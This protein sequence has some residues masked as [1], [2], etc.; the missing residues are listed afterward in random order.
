LL[1]FVLQTELKAQT[2]PFRGVLLEHFGGHTCPN[3]TRADSKSEQIK[4]MYHDSVAIINIQSGTFALPSTY[5]S[6]P[7][8]DDLSCSTGESLDTFSLVYSTGYPEGMI[9]RT[10]YNTTTLTHLKFYS[11]W[12]VEV[13]SLVHQTPLVLIDHS[14]SFNSTT[15]MLNT[16]VYTEVLTSLAGNYYLS[17]Y[18]TE[19]SIISPVA[20]IDN[21]TSIDTDHVNNNLL[22][23]GINGTWG[24]LISSGTFTSGS[25]LTNNFNFH[26]DTL[27]K[28]H[29]CKVVCFVYDNATKEVLQISQKSLLDNSPSPL[30]INEIR[31][32]SSVTISPN[33]FTTQTTI[34]FSEDEP[35]ILKLTDLLGKDLKTW[36]F[37]GKELKLERGNLKS[38][39]Y[40]LQIID[41]KNKVVNKKI[42]IE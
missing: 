35:H 17:V 6:Y 42:V 9:S 10:D 28:A 26:L 12:E 30:S 15:R 18:L 1:N 39:I 24:T 25:I 7:F 33:P 38:G 34:T 22:R 23:A 27:W 5:M 19:D 32:N 8:P 4:A 41:E 3:C 11:N 21:T 37:T 31:N 16:T 40:F 14:N 20:D 36:H 29:H 13:N 2:T